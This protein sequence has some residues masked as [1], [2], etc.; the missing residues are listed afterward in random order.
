M[1]KKL[2]G[3]K[4]KIISNENNINS[5]ETEKEHCLY[6]EWNKKF[7]CYKYCK[8]PICKNKNNLNYCGN[9]LPLGE[10]GPNGIMVKCEICKVIGHKRRSYLKTLANLRR[11]RPEEV[12]LKNFSFVLI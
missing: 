11:K 8:L 1:E 10:E 12:F 5:N 4:T 6:K 2:L 3:Q 9:H 7:K